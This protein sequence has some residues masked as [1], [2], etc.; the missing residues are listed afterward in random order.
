[1]LA[2]GAGFAALVVVFAPFVAVAPGGVWRSVWGQASRP[3]Q[4]ESLGGAVLRTFGDPAIVATHG[5]LNV[6]G[7]GWLATVTTLAEIAALVALWAA[8]GRRPVDAQRLVRYSAAA[9]C[10]FIAFGKVISPQFLIW[11]VPT[12]PLVRGRRGLAAV[13]L[14]VAALVTTQ[15]YFPARYF[16]YVYDGRLAWVVLLRDVLLVALLAVLSLPARARARS[17]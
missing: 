7:A 3:L 8:F 2:F 16:P 17:A 6:A 14:L 12:V 11:L 13:A 5:S 9:L 4:I 1:L 15:V 10:A